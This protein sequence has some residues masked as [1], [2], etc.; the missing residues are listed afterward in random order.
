MDTLILAVLT[1]F[2]KGQ[3]HILIVVIVTSTMV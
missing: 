3:N 2:V 1:T